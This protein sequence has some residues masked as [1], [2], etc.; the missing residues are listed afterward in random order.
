MPMSVGYETGKGITGG[1]EGV[2]GGGRATDTGDLKTERLWGG[3]WEKQRE[4]EA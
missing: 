1:K 4:T 2:E 3:G